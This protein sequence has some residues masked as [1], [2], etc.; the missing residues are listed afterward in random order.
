M[1]R[2]LLYWY[3]TL[4]LRTSAGWRLGAEVERLGELGELGK[5]GDL[6]KSGETRRTRQNSA[7]SIDW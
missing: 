4:I 2:T 5:L 3:C 6:G 1:Q 7:K